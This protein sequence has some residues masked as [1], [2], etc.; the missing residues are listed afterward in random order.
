MKFF[1]IIEIFLNNRKKLIKF[2]KNVLLRSQIDI[3]IH[4]YNSF[5]ENV[6]IDFKES[7]SFKLT[8]YIFILR[9]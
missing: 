3:K 6:P 2:F 7:M 8:P 4:A 1:W 5:G 9:I